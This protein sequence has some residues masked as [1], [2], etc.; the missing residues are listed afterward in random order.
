MSL[1]KKLDQAKRFRVSPRQDSLVRHLRAGITSGKWKPG[2]QLPTVQQIVDEFDVS[3][4]TVQRA[5]H[6][7]NRDGF[8]RTEHRQGVFVA[9]R[10]PNRNRFALVFPHRP[11][12]TGFWSLYWKA[13][14]HAA[15][16]LEQSTGIE[17]PIYYDI[18]HHSHNTTDFE[19]LVDAVVADRVAGLIFAHSPHNLSGTPVLDHPGLPRVAFMSH[20]SM[21]GVTHVPGTEGLIARAVD[22]LANRGRRRI[23]IVCAAS[24]SGPEKTPL[25]HEFREALTRHGLNSPAHWIQSVHPMMAPWACNVVQSIVHKNQRERPDALIIADDNLSFDAQRGLIAA[26]IHT[27]KDVDVI[28]HCNYPCEPAA[29]IPIQL[30]GLDTREVLAACASVILQ[31]RNG[32]ARPVVPKVVSRLASEKISVESLAASLRLAES[33][34][35]SA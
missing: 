6:Q 29:S 26:G 11:L 20:A 34:S 2:Q 9:D 33:P 24:G 22:L 12:D 3:S 8:I 25:V 21:P 35:H 19:D 14:T 7:L 30:L 17:F 5:I 18:E 31:A 4:V 10:L 15:I 23:A 1:Y 28:S 16:E 32:V 27:P 13:L